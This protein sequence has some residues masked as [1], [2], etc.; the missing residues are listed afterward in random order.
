MSLDFLLIEDGDIGGAIKDALE[1]NGHSVD[2]ARTLKEGID[3]EKRSR[4]TEKFYNGICFDMSLSDSKP[5]ETAKSACGMLGHYPDP[6][7]RPV[8]IAYSSIDE[9]IE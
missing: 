4:E 2:W 8:F 7:N 3:L 5:H 6:K 9:D 1:D